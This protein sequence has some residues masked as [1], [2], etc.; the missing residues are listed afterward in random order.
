MREVQFF[1]ENKISR[2]DVV[3]A[4]GVLPLDVVHLQR[5]YSTCV[6][7]ISKFVRNLP[8]SLIP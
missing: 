2:L 8:I 3:L 6:F 4:D 7:P 5:N 1:K